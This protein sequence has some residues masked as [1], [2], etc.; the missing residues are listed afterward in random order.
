[1]DPIYKKWILVKKVGLSSKKW[2]PI[3]KR[4]TLI[5]KAGLRKKSETLF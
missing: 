2:D 1:M 4:K 3:W 5:E